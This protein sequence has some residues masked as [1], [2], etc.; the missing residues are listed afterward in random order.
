MV[1]RSLKYYVIRICQSET[2]PTRSSG[3]V[4]LTCTFNTTLHGGCAVRLVNIARVWLTH[5][6]DSVVLSLPKGE[7]NILFHFK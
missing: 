5:H 7:H 6:L 1:T 2:L 4:M 3:V